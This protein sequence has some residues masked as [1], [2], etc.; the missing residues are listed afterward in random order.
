ML[1]GTQADAQAL[2]T[3]RYADSDGTVITS[4]EY[5]DLPEDDRAIYTIEY[6][7]TDGELLITEA[8]YL[9]LVSKEDYTLLNYKLTDGELVITEAEYLALVSKEDYT[10]LNYKLTDGELVITAEEYNQLP[11]DQAAA[12]AEDSQDEYVAEATLITPLDWE[13]LPLDSDAATAENSQ[14][15]Y[16]EVYQH[17]E[18]SSVIEVS[19]WSV[20]PATKAEV[21]IDSQNDYTQWYFREYFAEVGMAREYIQ[22]DAWSFK[23]ETRLEYQGDYSGFYKRKDSDYYI[24]D[25][26]Y[27]LLPAVNLDALPAWIPK[28]YN[29]G[30]QVRYKEQSWI[31]EEDTLASDEP[32]IEGVRATA[33]LEVLNSSRL[34]TGDF[35]KLID[36]NGLEHFFAYGT[37]WTAGKN[38]KETADKIAAAVDA[39]LKFDA[40]S[41]QDSSVVYISQSNPG[42]AGNKDI[43]YGTEI[44][45]QIWAEG[46]EGGKGSNVNPWKK[47]PKQN[48]GNYMVNFESRITA[49]GDVTLDKNLVV[50]G[51]GTIHGD[52]IVQ[53]NLSKQNED[54][55]LVPIFSGEGGGPGSAKI[56]KVGDE[57][58]GETVYRPE[59]PF[60]AGTKGLIIYD[61]NFMFICTQDSDGSDFTKYAWKRV[62]I[63]SW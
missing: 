62:P 48:M 39:S 10:L 53:G 9:A 45:L 14:D 50:K 17:N 28:A 16:E 51:N 13:E 7:L 30:E 4:S 59:Q 27:D 46:F 20:L 5:D 49:E 24:A 56:L 47:T 3:A 33:K 22:P 36:T 40:V 38:E 63:T 18:N 44:P 57:L 21:D 54:G 2:Y 12:D 19:N 52:L 31:A 42:E 25:E 15:E 8:E 26:Y 58:D 32:S 1:E 41:S 60:S 23:S 61:D 37:D 35:F 55:E 34:K 6:K 11:D 29:K 43:I